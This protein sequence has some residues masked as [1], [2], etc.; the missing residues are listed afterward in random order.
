MADKKRTL[1]SSEI[2]F[3][4][5]D[6][7]Y[8]FSDFDPRPYSNRALSDDFLLEARKASNDKSA[9][10]IQLRFLIPKKNRNAKDE[11]KI[12][13]RLKDHFIRHAERAKKDYE[14]ALIC[15]LLFFFFGILIMFAAAYFLFRHPSQSLLE[16]FLVL[17]TE[18]A[19]W[20][21]FWEGL[22]MI[23]FKSKALKPNSVFYKK[24]AHADIYFQDN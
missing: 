19:G 20:F 1:K 6:Y 18:P 8:I 24:M 15:G 14:R 21:L 13:N 3:L 16:N 23:L 22:D 10:N 9:H 11:E 4:I 17:M 2:G 12:K 5:D 7:D